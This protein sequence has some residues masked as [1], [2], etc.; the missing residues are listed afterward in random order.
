M[1]ARTPFDRQSRAIAAARF[2]KDRGRTRAS[3]RQAAKLLRPSK[4]VEAQFVGA[5]RTAMRAVHKGIVGALA[6]PKGA[7]EPG[8]EPEARADARALP[9]SA[10]RRLFDF[11]AREVG[12]A[13]DRMA[14]DVNRDNAEGNALLG[15]QPLFTPGLESAVKHART[16]VVARMQ[17]AGK[18]YLDDVEKIVTDPKNLGLRVEDLAEQL[19]ARAAV[20]ASRAMFIARDTTSKTSAAINHARQRAAGVSRYVWSTSLDERVRPLHAELEGRRFAYDDPPVTSEDGDRNNPGEDWQC[21]CVAI[22]VIPGLDD[23][24]EPEEPDEEAPE[25]EQPDE[26]GEP[27]AAAGAEELE[28]EPETNEL[29]AEHFA[30]EVRIDPRAELSFAEVVG[31]LDHAGIAD[32]LETP[33]NQPELAILGNMP[34]G[35]DPNWEGYYQPSARGPGQV[36]INTNVYPPSRAELGKA[37]GDVW[38]VADKGEAVGSRGFAKSTKAKVQD[39]FIHELGHHVHMGRHAVGEG[40]DDLVSAAYDRL[41]L[42]PADVD[43][44]QRGSKL[45]PAISR[46]AAKDRWEYFAESFNAYMT[47]PEELEAHDLNGF[48]MVK[49]VLK[50]LRIEP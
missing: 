3:Q 30:G 31:A 47:Q 21:R 38:R 9:A 41:H 14:K 23:E 44:I 35:V 29:G 26:T 8:A 46:Y 49:Q 43:A 12:Q 18:A 17:R 5:L 33:A 11:M 40:I 24:E 27:A 16:D 7:V 34:A 22:P 19:E 48:T 42:D 45:S 2:R 13:H 20:S 10:E 1:R 36:V 50:R 25:P 28:P 4:R 39:S 32:W 37:W 6:L 15:I